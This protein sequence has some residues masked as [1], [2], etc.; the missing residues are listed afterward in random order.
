MGKR[1]P[2][3]HC[4]VTSTPL[5]RNGPPGKPV[6]CNACG[7]R[8][9][10]KGTLVNYTPGHSSED[11]RPR[12]RKVKAYAIN[13]HSH[14]KG[15][16][17]DK[18]TEPN[19][20]AHKAV[21]EDETRSG[22][23][24][25]FGMPDSGKCVQ[26]GIMDSNGASGFAMFP[27]LFCCIPSSIHQIP[28]TRRKRTDRIYY[29]PTP[30]EHLQ[31]SLFDVMRDQEF[32]NLTESAED[33]LIHE[34]R[35]PL[36]WPEIGLGTILIKPP[37]SSAEEESVGSSLIL[38]NRIHSVKG[39]QV[40]PP[41]FSLQSQSSKIN[42]K[43]EVQDGSAL[44]QW[45]NIGS[46]VHNLDAQWISHSSQRNTKNNPSS[47]SLKLEKEISSESSHHVGGQIL[48]PTKTPLGP[49]GFQKYQETPLPT[50][51][52]LRPP[53][54]KK[55]GVE[56][57]ASLC[58]S[59]AVGAGTLPPTMRP[60]GPPIFQ[61]SGAEKE[62]SSRSCCTVGAGTLLPSKRPLERPNSVASKVM[63]GSLKA[64]YHGW[65]NSHPPMN[66]SSLNDFRS[67]Q[68]AKIPPA[69]VQGLES[70]S[71][72]RCASAIHVESVKKDIA[73]SS[74][75]NGR[76]SSMLEIP[77]SLPVPIEETKTQEETEGAFSCTP[78]VC[79]PGNDCSS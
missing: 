26:L 45:N 14:Y 27:R 29:T 17:E 52:P 70:Y 10:T 36:S 23:S 57:K 7:S 76:V 56:K 6:L 18:T 21:S 73:G 16:P 5:W 50:K 9:R 25:G 77:L 13:P 60:F 66:P 3:C 31:K 69:Y 75:S 78:M 44:H 19:Y 61:A 8:W 40:P 20:G 48:L 30:V 39:T 65:T 34:C 11:R 55:S 71:R 47:K 67:G 63:Q 74:T 79:H 49:P 64:R 15:C 28:I 72:E 4:G 2:C 1:G 37:T 42:S 35:T 51:I 62:T 22:S 54:H 33:V 43:L 24:S 46:F 38:E 12:Q 53:S 59:L 32:S 58:F 68:T 41:F